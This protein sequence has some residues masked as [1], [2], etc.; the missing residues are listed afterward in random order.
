ME[1]QNIVNNINDGK[2]N[3]IKT[4]NKLINIKNDFFLEKVFNNLKKR[5][6]FEILKYN[7]NIKTRINI[8]TND[9]KEFCENYSS[10]EIEIKLV[11]DKYGKFINFKKENEIYYHIYFD[12]NKQEIKRNYINQNE[13]INIIKILI[14]YQIN[15]LE[16]LFYNCAFI[17]TIY[18]K[19][20]FRNNIKS[21]Y[22][23]EK[24][25][26]NLKKGKTLTL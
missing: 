1:F 10:I 4:I 24:V 15:S 13:K 26:N 25:F 2:I 21:K 11:D 14:N 20:F 23:L 7:Q 17:E 9:Y 5:K 6:L 12:N 16:E 18:F 22:I 3:Q 19:K 8:N